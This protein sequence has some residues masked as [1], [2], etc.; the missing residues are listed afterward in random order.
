M[1]TYLS[2]TDVFLASTPEIRARH[3]KSILITTPSGSK[4]AAEISVEDAD[5]QGRDA[6]K[7]SVIVWDVS[8]DER[9]WVSGRP[10]PPTESHGWRRSLTL[11]AVN[12]IRP[13][14]ENPAYDL[15]LRL[16]TEEV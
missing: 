14:E 2:T 4:K 10:P 15:L 3:N 1:P 9:E 6:D 13:N 5:P 7:C 16:P 8:T 12:L 11:D